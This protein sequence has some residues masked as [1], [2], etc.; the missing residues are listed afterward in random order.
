MDEFKFKVQIQDGLE[1]S[2]T[3]DVSEVK[4]G[5]GYEQVVEK[6]INSETKTIQLSQIGTIEQISPILDFVR[7]H[8]TKA[9]IWRNQFNEL[10]TYRVEKESIKYSMVGGNVK[11]N[12]T[13]KEA[14]HV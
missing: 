7:D 5:D 8:V 1:T 9:F 4:F 12:F 11:L 13:F 3:K 6:G 10:G 2:I 14:H